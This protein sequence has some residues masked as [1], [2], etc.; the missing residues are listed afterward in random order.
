MR[1]V[2]RASEEDISPEATEG[3]L[4][5]HLRR[6]RL[7][8]EESALRRP[9]AGVGRRMGLSSNQQRLWTLERVAPAEPVYNVT[10]RY[11]VDGQLDKKALQ[12]SIND[13]VERHHI[14]R[15]HYTEQE[16]RPVQLVAPDWHAALAEW[17]STYERAGPDADALAEALRWLDGLAG[18]PFDLSKPPILRAALAR[19]DH[20]MNIVQITIHHIATDAWSSRILDEE[21]WSKY[22]AHARG[23]VV[24]RDLMP[25]QYGDYAAWQ[26]RAA[27]GAARSE[28]RAYWMQ[29]LADLEYLELSPDRTSTPQV[30]SAGGRV[31]R[32]MSADLLL[33]LERAA[34]EE[35]SSLFVVMQAALYA[36]LHCYTGREDLATGTAAA[37]RERPEFDA[38][39]GFF[40]NMIVLRT[41]VGQGMTLRDLVKV[42]RGTVLDAMEYQGFPFDALVDELAPPRALGRNPLFHVDFEVQYRDRPVR[43]MDELAVQ[44]IDGPP[45]M[46][47]WFDIVVMAVRG[48]STCELSVT[49]DANRFDK[50]RIDAFL[51][52]YMCVLTRLVQSPDQLVADLDLIT[53]DEVKELYPAPGS[54]M[55]AR[56]SV[57]RSFADTARTHP[58]EPALRSSRGTVSYGELMSRVALLAGRLADIGL[59]RGD[60]VGVHVKDRET[61]P[62]CL[63]AVLGIGA[64]FVP[65]D[66]E[67]PADRLRSCART[68]SLAAVI[69]D[70]AEATEN[71]LLGV[72]VIALSDPESHFGV[73]SYEDSN[74][75]DQSWLQTIADESDIAYIIFTS[76]STGSPKAVAV[77]HR[78]IGSLVEAISQEFR[79][80]LGTRVAQFASLSFDVFM[81]D[82]LTTLTRG[83]VLCVPDDDLRISPHRLAEYLR[84]EEVEV[85]DL[86]PA[87]LSLMPAG[88]CPHLRILSVGGEPFSQ[89]LVD[90]W[91]SASTEFWNTY[92]PTETTVISLAQRCSVGGLASQPP[93]GKPL[94]GEYVIILNRYGHPC[95]IGV[96]GE[97]FIGGDGVSAGYVGDS[98]LTAAKFVASPYPDRVGERMYRTGDMC[99]LLRD[100]TIRYLGRIDSVVKIRGFRVSLLEVESAISRFSG[101][102]QVVVVVTGGADPAE[103]VL[104]AYIQGRGIN[105]ADLRR[106]LAVALPGYMIPSV[107][108]FLDALPTTTSGKIDKRS[109]ST[110][111]A[112]RCVDHRQAASR[113]AAPN[114]SGNSTPADAG[115][116]FLVEGVFARLLAVSDV[117]Q[118]RSFFELGGN[119][120]QLVKVCADLA[121]LGVSVEPS[122]L[123]TNQS[124]QEIVSLVA[125]RLERAGT[126]RGPATSPGTGVVQLQAGPESVPVV[127]VHDGSGSLFPYR[128]LQRALGRS[129]PVLGLDAAPLGEVPT[130]MTIEHLARQL[131]ARLRAHIGSAPFDLLGW[132]F[133]GLLAFELMKQAADQGLAG[134]RLTMVDTTH[135]ADMTRRVEPV[136]QTFL[137]HLFADAQLANR[138]VWTGPTTEADAEWVD[139]VLDVVRQAGGG[140]L[141]DTGAALVD[142]LRLFRALGVAG[143]VYD[144]GAL[145]ADV[146]L[147]NARGRAVDGGS[148]KRCI[149]GTLRVTVLAGDHFSVLRGSNA[150]SIAALVT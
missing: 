89:A 100:K 90:E 142:R 7:S 139:R 53:T 23:E 46:G 1:D 125:S 92:G 123:M 95:P 8:W 17:E 110:A 9:Q 70:S 35:R 14:L 96:P 34:R 78:N 98:A 2:D 102:E 56:R 120:L 43:H 94:R 117:P 5:G 50:D 13:L 24:P 64:S 116:A 140:A 41:K 119:S 22:E 130:E 86:P 141:A 114:R 81:F 36:L 85:I 49:Y 91:A 62:I 112:G 97:L 11:R 76:G 47:T 67:Y 18:M 29:Q 75:S 149:H 45:S 108:E 137:D 129:A 60:R 44:V 3:R 57:V 4:D 127:L 79:V 126:G 132:S 10:I 145:T 65:L 146:H 121:S 87:L 20:T 30:G 26:R 106:D 103:R 54:L 68:V 105:A 71:L 74:E 118:D 58:D 6:A 42:T 99:V 124:V 48:E 52:H 39:I 80:L 21:L 115:L 133:G 148:W 12:R 147:V 37:G 19:V 135:P 66:T 128:D 131:L 93:I 15:T 40:V 28:A 143:S 109:L 107:I 150:D 27:G 63:L 82:V 69:G 84:S 16:G 134:R 38:M 32:V 25:L 144:P 88:R 72:P 33:G 31:T 59:G 104:M 111:T 73:V 55:T 138:A 83:G 51:D 122:D 77:T 61:L 113:V 101:V 136:E